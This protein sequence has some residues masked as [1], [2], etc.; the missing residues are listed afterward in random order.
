M[1][2]L[3]QAP[4]RY[5]HAG[6]VNIAYQV[7]GHGPL[8]IV[9]VPGL[10]NLI[11]ATAEVPAIERH[12]ERMA[13]FSR[14]I[15]FD[16]RGTGLSD[17]VPS[18]D[19]EL[20]LEDV[21]AVLD[22]NGLDSAVLFATADGVPIAALFAAR[23]PTRV[24]ALVLYEATARWLVDAGYDV[25]VPMEMVPPTE[26]VLKWWGDAA[27][28]LMVE[29][30]APSV[31]EDRGWRE[32]LARMQRRAA[33][34]TAAY[35]YWQQAMVSMDVRGVL[36]EIAVP[37]LVMHCAG[38]ALIPVGQ[39]RFV[40]ETIPGARFVELPGSDHFPWFE[41]GDRVA[42]ETE[43]FLLGAR[44]VVGAQRVSTVLFTDLVGSTEIASR[45]GTAR[46][47]D[48]LEDHDRLLQREVGRFGGRIVKTTGDGVLAMF[49]DPAAAVLCGLR[50]CESIRVMGVELRAAAHTGL[51]ELRG[52]DIAGIAVNIAAR[53]LAEAEPSEMLVTRTVK[54][55]LAGSSLRFST[56]GVR[57]LK[58]VPDEWEIYAAAL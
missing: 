23:Y 34:P 35:E 40:A 24:D 10:L 48:F 49:D 58:G 42:A 16:K 55:L 57:R 27:E 28:P 36:T 43:E 12:F 21:R 30:V 52:E 3:S 15:I 8:T 1:S 18:G 25:G 2:L 45:L 9:Y 13:A 53:V 20:R 50:V 56:R 26:A 46:W 38:D 31:A 7:M 14:V 4:I 33:T 19:V 17:R 29:I 32:A 6:G 41:N 51:I 47:R 44:H 11:E 37:T 54:D 5:A 39:G 22:A